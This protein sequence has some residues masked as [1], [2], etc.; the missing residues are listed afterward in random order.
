MLPATGFKNP[1]LDYC[2]IW[3]KK[4]LRR[5][6]RGI[7]KLLSC[8]QLLAFAQKIGSGTISEGLPLFGIKTIGKRLFHNL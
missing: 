6:F 7:I 5:G 1:H 4:R 3:R 8:F 2:G